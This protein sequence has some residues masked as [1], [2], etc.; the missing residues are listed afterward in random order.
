MMPTV[1]SLGSFASFAAVSLLLLLLRRLQLLPLPQS[2]SLGCSFLMLPGMLGMGMVGFSAAGGRGSGRRGGSC[3]VFVL[4]AGF[5][6]HLQM[7][8]L[9]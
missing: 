4:L 9:H 1:Q 7:F 3:C 2:A 6:V 8:G 5:M